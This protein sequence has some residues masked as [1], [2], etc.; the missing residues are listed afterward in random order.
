MTNGGGDDTCRW[1]SSN[2]NCEEFEYDSGDCCKASCIENC[3]NDGSCAYSCGS[4]SSPS[5]SIQ[6]W[7]DCTSACADNSAN[8]FIIGD[9]QIAADG[10][11]H[12]LKIDSATTNYIYNP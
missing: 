8:E 7:F 9:Q 10:D 11:Y 12:E 3:P 5:N 2:F 1:Y 6:L 4:N